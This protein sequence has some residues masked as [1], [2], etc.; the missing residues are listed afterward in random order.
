[1]LNSNIILKR[2]FLF[3]ILIVLF[4]CKSS[5]ETIKIDNTRKLEAVNDL[6]TYYQTWV[7]GVQ[8]GGSGVNLVLSKS[9]LN[10]IIPIEVY[11]RNKIAPAMEKQFEFTAYFKG[12]RN[13]LENLQTENEGNIVANE[14]MYPF[15]LKDNEAII[16]YL[17]LGIKKHLKITNI[18]QKESPAYPRT[19]PQN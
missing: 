1:M 9:F 2:I 10:D 17:H 6:Q 11:F 7:A 13:Q 4:Q 14:E 12:D 3:T 15:D 8:G 19:R 5:S 16:S 18:P